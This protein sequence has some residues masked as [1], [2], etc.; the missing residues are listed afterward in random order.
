MIDLV[1]GII[2]T[3]DMFKEKLE[4]RSNGKALWPF[5][6][7]VLNEITRLHGFIDALQL[8]PPCKDILDLT[9]AGP[10]V[11]VTNLHVRFRDAEIARLHGSDRRNRM[12]RARNEA[13]RTNAAI[14]GYKKL[15]IQLSRLV[16]YHLLF[17]IKT[18]IIIY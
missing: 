4:G 15:L 13:E 11:G 6:L 1:N 17:S 7:E 12:H 18:V 9:D 3:A 16:L 8:P 2:E 10:G 5:C 14:G